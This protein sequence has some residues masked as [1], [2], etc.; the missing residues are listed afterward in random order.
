MTAKE[1]EQAA[2]K[3]FDKSGG[4]SRKLSGALALLTIAFEWHGSSY[5]DLGLDYIS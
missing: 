5:I 2:I 4:H 1:A 3:D